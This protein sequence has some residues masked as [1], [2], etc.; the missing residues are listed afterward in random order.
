MSGLVYRLVG[1]SQSRT[2]FVPPVAATRTSKLSVAPSARRRS[3]RISQPTPFVRPLSEHPGAVTR[4]PSGVATF[5]EY[6]PMSNVPVFMTRTRMVAAPSTIGPA[7]ARSRSV[8]RSGQL[9]RKSVGR[10]ARPVAS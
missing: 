10:S 7:V 3:R 9:I 4:T 8:V 2:L 1:A 5:N 6:P